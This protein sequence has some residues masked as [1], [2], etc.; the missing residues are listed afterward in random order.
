MIKLQ[1][2]QHFLE[3]TTENESQNK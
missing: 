3:A 1:R 2:Q